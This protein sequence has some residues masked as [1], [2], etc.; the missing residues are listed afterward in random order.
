MEP[1]NDA[2]KKVRPFYPQE[3]PDGVCRSL[4]HHALCVYDAV[5][6]ALCG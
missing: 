4:L 2:Y 3:V 1:E 6:M 5:H